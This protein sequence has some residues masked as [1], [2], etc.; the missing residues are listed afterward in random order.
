MLHFWLFCRF[1]HHRAWLDTAH[2]P[3][4]FIRCT[5]ARWYGSVVMQ[6]YHGPVTVLLAKLNQ[7]VILLDVVCKTTTIQLVQIQPDTATIIGEL[8]HIG[9]LTVTFLLWMILYHGVSNHATTIL[10]ALLY[11]TVMRV[12]PKAESRTSACV[13]SRHCCRFFTSWRRFWN[14]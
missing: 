6:I 11:Q 8:C 4:Q 14:S 13:L 10:R 1:L 7:H 3:G 12:S 2:V 9:G 5:G